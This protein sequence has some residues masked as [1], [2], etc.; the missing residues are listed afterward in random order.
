MKILRNIIIGFFLFLLL[1]VSAGS[2]A[3]NNA[4]AM[5]F[6]A[7][8]AVRKYVR[9]VE[10]KELKFG[11]LVY[12]FPSGWV[13]KDVRI[14]LLSDKRLFTFSSARIEI[15]DALNWLKPRRPVHVV[16]SE[17]DGVYDKL[18]VSGVSVQADVSR[19]GARA[20]FRGEIEAASFFWD[21]VG[22]SAAKVFFT[23]DPR[24]AVM[25][26]IQADVYG[27]RLTGTSTVVFGKTPRYEV[28]AV[29]SGVDI[30]Q[31][32]RTLGGAFH[33]LGGT[34]SGS[35]RVAGV[36]QQINALDMSWNMPSGGKVSAA[37]LASI[38]S[39]LPASVEKK[40]IDSLIRSGGKLAVEVFSFTIR[41]DMP[42]HLSGTIGLKSREANL[43]LNISHEVKVD[44]RLDSLLTAWGVVFKQP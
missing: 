42:D 35:A 40:R 17:A 30:A 27:G 36:G 9:S 26:N 31:L 5:G 16:L 39:Y 18:K 3:V 7:R 32:D 22:G 44:A 25:N 29:L 34:L 6:I 13:L 12:S 10:V 20:V 21:K 14:R 43:E 24:V 8:E 28:N 15:R 11:S 37:L 19:E 38:A 23:A 2:Y 4:G 1:V 41:N 33:E